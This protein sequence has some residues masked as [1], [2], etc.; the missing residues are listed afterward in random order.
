MIT[1]IDRNGQVLNFQY[2]TLN[3]LIKKSLPGNLDTL[4][5]YDQVGK[6]TS[7]SDPDSNLTFSYDLAERLTSVSTAGSPNQPDVTIN[8]TYDSNGNRIAMTDSATTGTTD[9][10]YDVLNRITDI[11]NPTNQA[12]SFGYDNLGRRINTTLPNGIT[13]GFVYDANSQLSS[14]QHNLGLTNLSGF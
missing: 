3:Q 10:V 11:T 2:D 7:V 4:F 1:E 5:N 9:Y 6:L 13:T 12:I 14:L 8:Y